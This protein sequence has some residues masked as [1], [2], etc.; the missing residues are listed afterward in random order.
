MI[1]CSLDQFR[2]AQ[3]QKRRARISLPDVNKCLTAE[4]IMFHYYST[5]EVSLIF[6]VI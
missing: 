1:N 5:A 2:R 4:T 3:K 6:H